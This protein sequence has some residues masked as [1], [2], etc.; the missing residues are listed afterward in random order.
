M[1]QPGVFKLTATFD[2][3]LAYREI[4]Q[5]HHQRQRSLGDRSTGDGV[6]VR[7]DGD[8]VS[9][10]GGDDDVKDLYVLSD[11]DD[12]NNMG[13]TNKTKNKNTTTTTTTPTVGVS[14]GQGGSLVEDIDDYPL[15][16]A[17]G[18]LSPLNYE[19]KEACT[20]Q[21][22]TQSTYLHSS[23]NNPSNHPVTP[24]LTPATPYA[25]PYMLFPLIQVVLK[26]SNCEWVRLTTPCHP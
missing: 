23:A 21:T 5:R 18:W 25:L 20:N 2:P 24:P 19:G 26:Q 1:S 4:L 15:R 17:F 14:Q 6:S 3:K 8:G 7:G 16:D 9:G 10:G 11:D 12:D 22:L 13:V